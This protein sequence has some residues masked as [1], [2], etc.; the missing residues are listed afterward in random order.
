M[1]AS[2][3]VNV[4]SCARERT[5]GRIERTSST[6]G[7]EGR[8]RR[9]EAQPP[10]GDRTSLTVEITVSAQCS[11]EWSRTT[12]RRSS[13]PTSARSC[14]GRADDGRRASA[15]APRGSR[16]GAS[17]GS[18]RPL[19]SGANAAFVVTTGR[20]QAAASKT[21]LSS[22]APARGSSGLTTTSAEREQ[23][24]H[25]GTRDRR[26]LDGHASGSPS[27]LPLELATMRHLVGSQRRP[28]NS[29]VAS[30]APAIAS[31]RLRAG[32]ASPFQRAVRPKARS[33]SAP[34]CGSAGGAS[35]SV[36][37]DRMPDPAHLR[38]CRAGSSTGRRSG[39]RP[40]ASSRC[41]ADRLACQCVYQ[42]SSGTRRN[43]RRGAASSAKCRDHVDKHAVCPSQR[44]R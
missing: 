3:R 9:S 6:G 14:H 8:A 39:R 22:V 5:Y 21:A 20:A 24:G 19:R 23:P 44:R 43:A 30:S 12:R 38:R 28:A 42:R 7:G 18:G 26:G 35:N 41:E 31:R 36:D 4:L 27:L 2:L 40:R 10:R 25:V 33:R 34:A 37:V 32:C 1:L 11:S 15:R 29:S 16:A 13:A 17:S